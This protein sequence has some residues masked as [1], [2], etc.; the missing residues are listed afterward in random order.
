MVRNAFDLLQQASLMGPIPVNDHKPRTLRMLRSF[1]TSFLLVRG[2][3][4][5][6]LPSSFTD[7]ILVSLGS[8]VAKSCK[9]R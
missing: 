6:R 2:H 1:R 8:N 4:S 5:H 9:F 7:Q 3:P